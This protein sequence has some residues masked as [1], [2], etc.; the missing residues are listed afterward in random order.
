MRL[1]RTYALH[2]VLPTPVSALT[3]RDA[4]FEKE[5]NDFSST[6]VKFDL[7]SLGPW[8]HPVKGDFDL[9]SEVSLC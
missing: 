6:L 1:V 2:C 9:H 8:F 5:M 7:A 3:S 4:C